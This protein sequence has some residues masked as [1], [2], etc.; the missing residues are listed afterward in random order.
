MFGMFFH[1]LN[2]A[3]PF[4]TLIEDKWITCHLHLFF[5]DMFGLAWFLRSTRTCGSNRGLLPQSSNRQVI[6]ER[7][8]VLD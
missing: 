3:Q 2:I 7:G 6:G 1:K 8:A 5:L 4:L